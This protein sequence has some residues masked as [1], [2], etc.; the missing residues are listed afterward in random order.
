M[1]A[2]PSLAAAGA[3][4][5]MGMKSV[6]AVVVLIVGG[7]FLWSRANG[8]QEPTREIVPGNVQPPQEVAAK[9]APLSTPAA[10]EQESRAPAA[11][12]ARSAAAGG[13]W[14]FE[15]VAQST[16]TDE[17]GQFEFSAVRAE[18][19]WPLWVASEGFATA[20]EE[21]RIEPP[22]TWVEITLADGRRSTTSFEVNASTT[23]ED[24]AVVL[25][26]PE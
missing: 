7:A 6:A 9:E 13:P 19:G 3:G 25:R 16:S 8:R 5:T 15:A 17:Q 12:N 1:T 21:L 26:A 22:E 14:L 24:Q 10:D 4:W 20:F 2:G 23:G 11:S 18:N